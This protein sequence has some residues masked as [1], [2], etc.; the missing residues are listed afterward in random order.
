MVA[1]VLLGVAW[2][3]QVI[4]LLTYLVNDNLPVWTFIRLTS[5]L[6]PDL[7][8]IIIPIALF[9][10]ILFVYNRLIA[11]KEMIIMEGIGLSP[12]QLA[13]PTLKMACVIA[14]LSASVTL[15]FSNIFER[16]YKSFLWS[17]KND[18]SSLLVRAGE[19]NQLS[20]GTTIYVR[21]TSGNI[22]SD[23][24]VR[25]IQGASERVITA[26]EGMVEA[27]RDNIVLSLKSGSMQEINNGKY[28]F[29]DFDTY[30]ADLGIV[31]AQDTRARRP[32]ELSTVELIFAR[33]RGFANSETWPVFLNEFHRRI[34]NPL[35]NIIMALIALSGVLAA[36]R[37][38]RTRGLSMTFAVAGMVAIQGFFIVG[39]GIVAANKNLFWILYLVPSVVCAA[40]LRRIK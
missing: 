11:D 39:Y 3:S 23:I 5:L 35:Q 40:L 14:V 8:V 19:F 37:N 17:A 25:D 29:G 13:R 31:A 24:F 28:T 38:Q 20:P 18:L 4:R 27:T 15:H 7:L 33:Q 10:V 9:S 22:L 36:S 34:L 26:R 2:F 12:R 6:L 30:T 32:K 21:T 16:S 1:M